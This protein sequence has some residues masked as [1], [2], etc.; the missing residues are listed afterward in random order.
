MPVLLPVLEFNNVLIMDPSYSCIYSYHIPYL[1]HTAFACMVRLAKHGQTSTVSANH[2][3]PHP[4][5]H[6]L[7]PDSPTYLRFL[8]TWTSGAGGRA[9]EQTAPS[10]SA[11][12]TSGTTGSTSARRSPRQ[13]VRRT[14]SAPT[15]SSPVSRA[16]LKTFSSRLVLRR[17]ESRALGPASSRVG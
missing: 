1:H 12:S 7:T 8:R 4:M 2:D 16:H 15:S 5:R 9:A 10:S 11:T 17:P 3:Q 6:A 14:R 13:R